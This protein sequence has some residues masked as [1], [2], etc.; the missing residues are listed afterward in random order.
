M[1]KER[2]PIKKILAAGLIVGSLDILSAI[3]DTWVSYKWTPDK[4]L[5]Y[6][7]GAAFDKTAFSVKRY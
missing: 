7:A 1:F 2:I 4:V 3:I 6:I 5:K